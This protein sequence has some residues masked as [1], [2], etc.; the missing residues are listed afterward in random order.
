MFNEG[1]LRDRN[2]LI[3]LDQVAKCLIGHIKIQSV[4]VIEVVLG[5]INCS[6]VDI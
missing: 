6:F 1:I 2:G 3:G 4:G 5:D